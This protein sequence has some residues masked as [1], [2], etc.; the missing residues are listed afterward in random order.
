MDRGRPGVGLSGFGGVNRHLV[1][2]LSLFVTALL[3]QPP[4][5]SIRGKRRSARQNGYDASLLV[6][7]I[8]LTTHRLKCYL[9]PC[10]SNGIFH[11]IYDAW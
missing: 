9:L 5:P 7:S 6:C 1:D 2:T 4:D 10:V 11:T 8:P 3:V